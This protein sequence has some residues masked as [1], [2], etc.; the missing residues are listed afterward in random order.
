VIAPLE[1]FPLLE[2]LLGFRPEPTRAADVAAVLGERLRARGCSDARAYGRL[3][4]DPY[5]RASEARVVADRLTVNET[6]FLREFAQLELIVRK[7]V[8]SL[9]E[10]GE[11]PVRV[12]SAGCSTGEEPYG[13]ALLLHEAGVAPEQVELTGIDLSSSAI[14]R[15][16]SARYSDWSL[17]N[18]PAALRARYFERE[19]K[20][21]RLTDELRRRVRFEVVNVVDD[22]FFWSSGRFD[23]VLCRNLLIYLSPEAIELAVARFARVLGEGGA[24]FLGHAETSLGGPCFEV[25]EAMGA[26]YFRR[27]SAGQRP[28][29]PLRSLR[30]LGEPLPRVA[31]PPSCAPAPTLQPAPLERADELGEVVELIRH[32][33]FEDALACIEATELDEQSERGLLRAV[34]LTN[35][36][37]TAE[38]ARAAEARLERVPGC[39]FAHYLLG[40]CQESRLSLDEARRHYARATELEPAFAM[41][42]LRAG[43][44]ARRAGRVEEARQALEAALEDFP[45]Q[46]TRTLLLYGSG[47]ARETLASLCRSELSALRAQGRGQP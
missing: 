12:L 18:V 31:A 32:E 11:T 37:R 1:A 42:Q 4:D 5:V 28:S 29:L 33:R 45:R 39:P 46:A 7:I 19:Q 20:G 47:F 43:M 2:R 9:I 8:P 15:A 16:R 30:P 17:R 44:L 10:R 6:Y 40:L 34:I 14:A 36:G 22:G 38:A 35:L 41:A 23:V 25:D 13:L 3:L 26:F 21:F 24:L 27:R